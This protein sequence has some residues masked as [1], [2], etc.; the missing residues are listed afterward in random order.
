MLIIFFM[1]ILID[2]TV[3]AN[4]KKEPLH[5]RQSDNVGNAINRTRI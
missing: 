3:R 4:S 1:F 2:V 5:W